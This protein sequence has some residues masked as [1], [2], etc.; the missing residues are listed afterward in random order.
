MQISERRD[1]KNNVAVCAGVINEA[2]DPYS[3]IEWLELLRLMNVSM[4]SIS[5][6]NDVNEN[7]PG[8]KVLSY[9]SSPSADSFVDLRRTSLIGTSADPEQHVLH[10]SPAINDCMY[11]NMYL[12][13][14]NMIQYYICTGLVRCPTLN[15]SCAL[16]FKSYII[17]CLLNIALTSS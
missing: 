6:M 9:Y 3:M 16:N 11:R 13:R 10:S 5:V 8:Y 4:L 14:S 2:P 7:A 15:F 12:Y 1:E 17:S